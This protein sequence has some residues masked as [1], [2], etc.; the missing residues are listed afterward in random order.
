MYRS[1]LLMAGLLVLGSLMTASAATADDDI[2]TDFSA[3][4]MTKNYIPGQLYDDAQGNRY[5]QG[6]V[7]TGQVTGWPLRGSLRHAAY[8]SLPGG[9]ALVGVARF[10]CQSE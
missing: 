10:V 2:K 4:L 7:C 1:F 8:G 5:Y 6:S 9:A 3:I